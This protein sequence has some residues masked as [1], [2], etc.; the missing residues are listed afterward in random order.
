MGGT[1]TIDAAGE[2]TIEIPAGVVTSTDG[3]KNEA[4]NY[5]FTIGVTEGIDAVDAEAENDVIYDLTGRRIAEIVK[6][7]IYI[8]NGKKVL[9]K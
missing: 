5:T 2:Y 7:G 3:A 9:V 1:K 6:P 4:A 8:V